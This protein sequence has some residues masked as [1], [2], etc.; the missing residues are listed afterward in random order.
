MAAKDEKKPDDKGTEDAPPGADD[1]GRPPEGDDTQQGGGDDAPPADGADQ[2]QD[3]DQDQGADAGDAGEGEPPQTQDGNDVQGDAPAPAQ[4][5]QP[6]LEQA[7]FILRQL[8][9]RAEQRR[10]MAEQE[11]SVE[12]AQL[13]EQQNAQPLTPIQS[14]MYVSLDGDNIGNKVAAA[15]ERND[16]EALSEISNRINQGQELLRQWATQYGGKLIEAGGDEG[17]VKVPSSALEDVENLRAQYFNLVGATAT[18]GVGATLSQSTRARELGKLRGKNQTVQ[19][20]DGLE[21][22]LDARLRDEGPQDERTKIQ[23]A[24]LGKPVDHDDVPKWGVPPEAH[25][26]VEEPADDEEEEGDEET[27]GD[28]EGDDGT[29][30]DDQGDEQA[31]EQEQETQEQGNEDGSKK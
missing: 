8:L 20:F 13:L 26:Q 12:E 25:D 21:Q 14:V 17:L 2:G 22:E 11:Q 24:G 3:P 31:Q 29:E 7:V 15:E 5:A 28:P 19:Y 9:T 23:A 16:E 10:A 6:G 27:T 1:Q 18:V 30:E 4:P